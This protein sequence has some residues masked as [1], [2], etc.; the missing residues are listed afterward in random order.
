MKVYKVGIDSN[1]LQYK[2]IEVEMEIQYRSAVET[3]ADLPTS[4]NVEGDARIALDNNHL[5]VYLNSEWLDQGAYDVMDLVQERLMQ[6][7]S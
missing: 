5:Y 1:K 7:L 3:V 4:D 6:G 2:P